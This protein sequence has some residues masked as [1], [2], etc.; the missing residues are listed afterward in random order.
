LL[1]SADSS[2]VIGASSKESGKVSD[3]RQWGRKE[4][5]TLLKFLYFNMSAN[6]HKICHK[7]AGPR[8]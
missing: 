1:L 6:I 2:S 4:R 7:T 5:E 8:G 3:T